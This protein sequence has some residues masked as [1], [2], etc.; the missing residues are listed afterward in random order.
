MKKNILAKLIL[1][2]SCFCLMGC[3]GSNNPNPNENNNQNPQ[4]V[5]DNSINDGS[6]FNGEAGSQSDINYDKKATINIKVDP[7]RVPLSQ[8]NITLVITPIEGESAIYYNKSYE[9]EHLKNN[10]WTKV[11][12]KE[13]KGVFDHGYDDDNPK[14]TDFVSFMAKVSLPI[15]LSDHEYQ[16]VAGQYRITQKA[17]WECP[18]YAPFEI[19]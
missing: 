17:S 13:G 15:S 7:E 1:A 10:S 9:L 14:G 16:F 18:V 6:S 8:K 12:F 5:P 3:G 11:P 2:S 4:S 19:Y